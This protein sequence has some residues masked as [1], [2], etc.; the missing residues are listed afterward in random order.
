MNTTLQEITTKVEKIHAALKEQGLQNILLRSIPNCLYITGSVSQSFI[1]VDRSRELPIIFLERP[2]NTL[3]GYPEEL[4]YNIRKPELIPEILSDIGLSINEQTALELGYLPVTEYQRLSKLSPSGV[5][6]A[7]GSTLMRNVRSIKTEAELTETRRLAHVHAEIY[8][9]VPEF[10]R[11]GITDLELQHELEY[12]MRRR[13]SIGIFRAFGARM[14]IHMG[15]MICGA[16]A[17]NPAPYD[18]TMGGKGVYAM[19]MGAS[20]QEILPGTT[21]MVD[22][23]GNYGVYQTDITRTYYLGELPEEVVRAHNLSI[24]F[25]RWFETYA[26][27]GTP[28]AEVYNYFLRRAEEEGFADYFM[29]HNNQVKFVGHGVGIEINEQPVLTA[30]SKETFRSGMVIALEPKF[31]F[32]EVGAVGLENTFII[33]ENG[34]E[35]IT[36]LPEELTPLVITE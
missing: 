9:L 23:S 16:N 22:L 35:N 34:A 21:L 36:P 6:T 19:P 15:N 14:E 5:S 20:G 7:D 33:G 10:Y 18:F 12:Q 25:Q 13:G 27:A 26:K 2:T 1:F 11:P 24:E 30:R 28:V 31:V 32:P 3:E 29:G 17:D 4:I 8:R